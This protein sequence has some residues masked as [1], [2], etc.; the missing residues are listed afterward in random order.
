MSD[1]LKPC[2]FCGGTEER[3]EWIAHKDSCFMWMQATGKRGDLI[4]AWQRRPTEDALR[5]SRERE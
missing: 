1:E 3:P 4:T 5:A 2:P